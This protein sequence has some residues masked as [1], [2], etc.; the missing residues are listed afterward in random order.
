ME[1]KNIRNAQKPKREEE[2]RLGKLDPD[3]IPATASEH[4][5]EIIFLR[6]I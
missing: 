2:K 6:T 4:R 3:F 1:G 5:S